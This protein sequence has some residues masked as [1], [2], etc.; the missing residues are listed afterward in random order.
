MYSNGHCNE[1]ERTATFSDYEY[2]GRPERD[3]KA[4]LKFVLNSSPSQLADIFWLAG[5][6]LAG[7]HSSADRTLLESEVHLRAE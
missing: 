7:T 1:T 6:S 2:R 4:E 3:E 5:C